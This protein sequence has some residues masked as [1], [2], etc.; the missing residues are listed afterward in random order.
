[1]KTDFA[2][3]PMRDPKGY[4]TQEEIR[5]LIDNADNP[6]DRLLILLL[7]RTGRRISEVLKLRVDDI[8]FEL[9]KIL[10]NILKQRERDGRPKLKWKSIDEATLNDLKKYIE[11][12]NLGPDDYIFSPKG[13]RNK[14]I[15]RQRAFQIIRKIGEKAG[16]IYVGSKKLHPHHFRHSVGIYLTRRFGPAQARIQLEH[17][18]LLITQ[19]YL[20]FSEKDEREIADALSEIV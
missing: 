6:R 5:K 1:M 7:A 18:S 12:Y 9:K 10:W 8:N 3:S 20:Q 19:N 11:T 2:S 15:S 14:P 16:I 17:S 4:L 13:R